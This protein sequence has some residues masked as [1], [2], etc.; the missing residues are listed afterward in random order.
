MLALYHHWEQKA[1]IYVKKEPAIWP[2]QGESLM[3]SPDFPVR[4]AGSAT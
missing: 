3:L 2:I 4:Q 1:R